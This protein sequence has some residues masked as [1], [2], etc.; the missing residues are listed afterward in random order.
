MKRLI[1]RYIVSVLLIVG[2]MGAVAMTGGYLWVR[3]VLQQHYAPLA[4]PAVAQLAD[5]LSQRSISRPHILA[6][7][8]DLTLRSDIVIWAVTSSDGRS[9]IARGPQKRDQ[10]IWPVYCTFPVPALRAGAPAAGQLKVWPSPEFIFWEMLGPDHRSPLLAA[11][12]FWMAL[13]AAL[14]A[15]YFWRNLLRPLQRLDTFVRHLYRDDPIV[16][17]FGVHIREWRRLSARLNRINEK[18]SDTTATLGMLFSATQALTS[19]TEINDVFAVIADI[20]GRKFGDVCTGLLLTGEDGYLRMQNHRGFSHDFARAVHLRSGEGYAGQAFR[21]KRIVIVHDI[22]AAD[23]SL[24]H[25]PFEAEG[26]ASFAHIPLLIED[27][28]IGIITFAAREKGFFTDDRMQT[29]NTLARYLAIALRNTRLYEH[30]QDL[31]QRLETEVSTTTRELI[32]TNSRLIQK[33]REMKALSDIAA[34]TV[35]SADLTG[36]LEMVIEKSKELL[37]A[38]AGGFFL[39]AAATDEL[40]PA[41]PFFGIKDRDFSK[42]SCRPGD[43]PLLE[44]VLRDGKSVILDGAQESLPPL[45]IL[46]GIISIRSL[47]LIPLRA[48]TESMGI[49]AVAN[50]YDAPF[51]QDDLHILGLIADRVAGL[52]ANVRLYQELEKRLRDL[53]TLQ[54]ISSAISGEPVWEK[55]L[56][57]IVAA[58][59]GAFE[60]DLC[61]LL[62]YDENARELV[63]Q[64]GAYFTGGDEAVLLRI[65]VDDPHSVSAQVF[66]SGEPFLS[67]DASI[68]IRIKSQTSRLWNVRSLILVP[69]KAENRLIGVLRIGRH[70][71]NCFSGEHLRLA[72]LIAHQAAII[73]ENAHLYKSLHDAKNE[74]EELNKIKNEFISM[75][76]HELRTPI[77][78]IK[79]FV[80]LVLEGETGALNDQQT[81]FLQIADQSVDRLTVLVS[82]LLDI[83]RIE[84]GQLKLRLDP[85]E[86]KDVID[87]AVRNVEAEIARKKLTLTVNLAVPFP[88]ILADRERLV[89][90]FNNLLMNGIKFT[91]DGGSLTVSAQDKGDFAVFS[92]ADTGIGIAGKDHQKIFEKFYQ[93]DSSSTRG[94]PG[95]GL[96]L[97]IV[98][99][100]VEMHGGQ[101][102]VE[103]EPGKGSVFRFIVP[104]AKLEIRDFRR[105]IA[106]IER[107]ESAGGQQ[108][109]RPA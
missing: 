5:Q 89:Q 56:Q 66:R 13:L 21:Q 99:S 16:L 3:A 86:P 70:K 50:K 62:F 47:A 23:Y 35:S 9:L 54:E 93:V 31:N 71:A 78:A 2:V 45:P 12:L 36:I 72:T 25:L 67:P 32:Q 39:Y 60:A 33:V 43:V 6:A 1:V 94:T 109:G 79:G 77:T 87:A 102:W 65:P 48:G 17:D 80:K 52:I 41:P 61:A 57:K 34:F 37:Q 14:L 38:Q 20:A 95:T 44:S 30:I 104:R 100:I 92:V 90:V 7:L 81:Q 28:C 107:T 82:D 51:G 76:S 8:Q 96:G 15:A 4:A 98:K 11:V 105:D 53:T 63:T 97:A 108:P 55:T 27:K 22:A 103:S 10:V 26:L 83:S 46:D 49:F 24:V 74:L 69:L 84:S 59:K 29:L 18:L 106:E 91:P 73:I 101:I 42:L 64:P 85:V 75:V 19:H 88:Q 68:D 58:A 40:I